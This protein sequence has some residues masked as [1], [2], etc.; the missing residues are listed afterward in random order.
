MTQI[1]VVGSLNMDLIVRAPRLPVPG[2]TIIG[3]E[4]RTAPGGKGA[5]QAVAAARLGASVFMVGRVGADDFGRALRDS[6]TTDRVDTTNVFIEKGAATGVAVIQ[7]DGMGQNT[8]V[9]AAGANARVTRADVDAARPILASAH[10]L[11][12]QLEIPLDTVTY[13]L[14]LARE[15]RVLTVLNPAPAQPLSAQ[16]L[17]LADL[18]VPNESEAALLTGISVGDWTS[19]EAAARE[20]NRR[21]APTVVVTLGARGALVLENGAAR[22]ISPFQVKATDATAAG[23]AFVAALAVARASGSD[24]DAALHEASAAGALTATRLG[25]QPSLPTRAEL[26]EFLKARD[27]E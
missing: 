14:R 5:N 11:I 16:V 6:L 26:D 9:V 3:H 19:A 24:L 21:G 7:V 12:V 23:D 1:V 10:A 18:L 20:L 17:S 2:E 4:F 25:A 27:H 15:A 13:A 22:R 8:I